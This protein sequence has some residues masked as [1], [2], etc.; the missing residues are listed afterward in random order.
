LASLETDGFK[1]LAAS[2]V[3]LGPD[4]I[5]RLIQRLAEGGESLEPETLRKAITAV[6]LDSTLGTPGT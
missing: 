4:E 5:M 1:Q 3:Y 2:R 6:G